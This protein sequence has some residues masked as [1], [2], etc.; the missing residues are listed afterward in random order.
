M[1]A[2]D[3]FAT[4]LTAV[5]FLLEEPV[6]EGEDMLG[7]AGREYRWEDEYFYVVDMVSERGPVSELRAGPHERSGSDTCGELGSTDDT[8]IDNDKLQV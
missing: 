7:T 1:S 6:E 5:R 2:V 8:L 4:P 3:V